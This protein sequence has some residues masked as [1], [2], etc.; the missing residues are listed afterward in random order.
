MRTTEETSE[1]GETDFSVQIVE[2]KIQK[3]HSIY[4]S[5]RGY[6]QYPVNF[7]YFGSAE[8]LPSV[9]VNDT[10][11]RMQIEKNEFLP[12]DQLGLYHLYRFIKA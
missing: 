11:I 5:I 2:P 6:L 9:S 3:I 1:M 10:P 7:K 8:Q 4:S 12:R